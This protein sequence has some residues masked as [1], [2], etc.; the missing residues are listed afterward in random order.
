MTKRGYRFTAEVRT[1]DPLPELVAVRRTETRMV[2]R[3]ETVI[4]DGPERVTVGVGRDV[5]VMTF[6]AEKGAKLDEID[7]A[8]RT[9][10]SQADRLPVDQAVDLLAGLNKRSGGTPKIKSA[11]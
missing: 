1:I 5:A 7:K 4:D 9:P 11:R 8:G 10:L 2:S 6:L 3:E